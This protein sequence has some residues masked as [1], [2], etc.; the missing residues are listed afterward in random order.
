MGDAFEAL[1]PSASVAQVDFVV[2]RITC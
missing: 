2:E 1:A